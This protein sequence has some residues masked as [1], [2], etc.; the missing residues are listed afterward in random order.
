[1]K[2]SERPYSS[3]DPYARMKRLE[4]ERRRRKRILLCWGAAALLVLGAGAAA[5]VHMGSR[6]KKQAAET[7]IAAENIVIEEKTVVDGISVKG[8]KRQ[9][10]LE[11]LLKN[12]PW[13]MSVTLG[14]NTYPV[15]NLY[16]IQAEVLLDTICTREQPGEYTVDILFSVSINERYGSLQLQLIDCQ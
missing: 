2:H 3:R 12:T 15:S 1:M 10:A 6:Q 7:E 13:N 9:E 14:E 11:T 16:Q 4:R 5:A 8:M